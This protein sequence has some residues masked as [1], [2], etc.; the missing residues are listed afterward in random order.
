MPDPTAFQNGPV[1]SP[2]FAPVRAVLEEAI[3]EGAI[4]GC[5]FGATAGGRIVLCDG[6][7]HFTPEADALPVRHNTLY[8]VASLT[9]VVATTAMAMLLYERGR[10][11]PAQLLGEVLPDF[12]AD[13]QATDPARSIRLEH[14]LAHSSG[15]PGYVEF[16]RT[17]ENRQ[18]LIEACFHLQL[19]AEPGTRAC[20]SDPGFILLGLALERLSGDSLESFTAR[21]IFAPLGMHCTF[22]RPP[23]ALRPLIPPTEI[24]NSLRH[25]R[26]QGE[27][28]DENCFVLGGASGHAGIFA[29]VRDLLLFSGEI[30]AARS[31]RGQLYSAETLERFARRQPPTGS[32]RALG[33]DTPSQPS[34]SGLYYAPHSIGHLGFS[35]SSLW[36]DL[37]AGMSAVLLT[38]RTWP[39]RSN[40][41]IRILRPAFH[42]VLRL[43]LGHT[44][45]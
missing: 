6:L 20:Y 23:E 11:D 18:E 39:D 28:Q 7:G 16:F 3:A 41:Q 22:F 33:W 35:G 10:L 21:E 15:L 12:V 14:L 34:S 43:A 1:M 25:R 19:E 4:P 13:R 17:A 5:A 45:H 40:Q 31:E 38:N 27:V 44:A 26:L 30:L 9:K 32:S 42:N 29:P 24:D 36:I 2:R 37:E 8:D